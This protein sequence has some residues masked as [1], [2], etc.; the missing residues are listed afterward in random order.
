MH[1]P[2]VRQD[3]DEVQAPAAVAGG[4]RL[5]RDGQEA[6]ALVD[7]LAAQ[8]IGGAA[9]EPALDYLLGP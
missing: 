9:V 8:A 4:A 1:A 6:V 7:H 5:A 2:A 3:L